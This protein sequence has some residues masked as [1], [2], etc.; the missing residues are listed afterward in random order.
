M[1]LAAALLVL[2]GSLLAFTAAPGVVP[3]SRQHRPD[4]LTRT[5]S[6]AKPQT[7]GLSLTRGKDKRRRPN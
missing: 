4:T 3:A 6:A 2:L 5:R 1:D 7:L